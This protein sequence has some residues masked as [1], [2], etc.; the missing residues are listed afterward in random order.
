MS[1]GDRPVYDK[2]IEG[3]EHTKLQLKTMKHQLWTLLTGIAILTLTVSTVPASA[4]TEN[5][6][7]NTAQNTAQNTGN[8]ISPIFS[9]LNLT[10]EQQEQIDQLWEDKVA[11]IQG[12]L[13][14]EQLEQFQ[15]LRSEAMQMRQRVEQLNLTQEQRE[16]IQDIM[17]DMQL[18]DIL[19]DEQKQQLRESM[20][21]RWMQR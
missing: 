1:D 6:P 10:A 8:I 20:R 16:Q 13:T 19:T 9:E 4:Q 18:G 3:L 17:R 15:A 14:L 11:R 2:C 12:I 21:S 5:I 7:Q